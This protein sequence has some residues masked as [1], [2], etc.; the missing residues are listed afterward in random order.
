MKRII[1]TFC[2]I[3]SITLSLVADTS[4]L[5]YYGL[6]EKNELELIPN[7]FAIQKSSDVSKEIFLQNF[8]LASNKLINIEWRGENMCIL[9][10]KEISE[11]SIIKKRLSQSK[12]DIVF[13]PLY[14]INKSAEGVLFPEIIVKTKSSTLDESLLS[15]YGLKLK[16]DKKR[17]QIYSV[18]K[19][20]DVIDIA[21]KIYETGECI[22]S[23]PHF[24]VP[25][26]SM[27]YIPNDT[28]F[29]Y[30]ITCHNT[31]Q[32]LP[33]G[34]TGSPDADIDAPDAW[35]ITKGSSDIIIAVFDE[36]VTSNHPD[37]PNSKQVRLNG[38]N[39]GSG[40]PN[41]P[42]P[43]GNSNHG[44]ACAGVIAASMNNNEGI[45]GIAPNCKIMPLRWDNSSSDAAMADGIYFAMDNGANIISCSWAYNSANYSSPV[46]ISAISTAIENNVVVV[47]SAGNTANHVNNNGGYVS[48][49]ANANIPYLI[50]VGASDRYDHVAN[51]SPISPLIDV[52]APSHKAYPSQISG[53]TLEMWSLDIPG[54][55]GYNPIPSEMS[56]Y[57][58]EGSI[59]P[60][61]GTNRLAYTGYFGGTSHSCPVVAGVVALMLSVNPFLTPEDVYDILTETI[62]T[63]DVIKWDMGG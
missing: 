53:E 14:H 34:H 54:F 4:K 61:S 2:L 23:Y 35:D 24:Q 62:I 58:P 41:D 39:F 20:S 52:V 43:T 11:I 38:S 18:P 12:E 27:A 51:Y 6:G 40:D 36:G 9:E 5:F 44:N 1:I 29:Q 63:E 49:P 48:F 28:Y 7:K 32:T 16:S 37:L 3:C 19:D 33:N 26:Q 25:A 55:A 59:L 60:D 56:D 57:A 15:K 22:F 30:Q 50:T 47:F 8:S 10:H 42:S 45:A 46:I 17:Y 13:L 21:N 31:G